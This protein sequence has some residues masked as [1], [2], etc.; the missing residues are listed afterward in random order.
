MTLTQTDTANKRHVPLDK[1]RNIGII[2][3]IDAG[4]TT[5]TERILFYT[6]RTYKLG[7]IDEGTT[8]MDWM[9]QERER[10][11]TIV[12][13]A[14]TAFWTPIL[15]GAIPQEEYR[16]NIIDTPGHV[17]F[18]A[19]VERSLRVLDGGITVLDAEEGVQSQS[20]TVWHQADKYKVPRLCFVNKMDK[21]GAD[22]QATVQDIRDRLGANPVIMA[23][24]IG[25]EN[26]F[27]GICLLLDQKALI[28]KGDETGAKYDIVD[29]PADMKT[30]VKKYRTKLIE[31]ISEHDDKLLEKFLNAEEPTMVELKAALRKAVIAYKL[32]PV[33]CGSSLRN[34]GVQ[35]LLDAVVE[36]LPSPVDLRQV[37][38][39]NPKT[40]V[41]EIR[42]CNSEAPFCGLAF[43]I[44]SDPHVGRL[45]YVRIYSGTLKSGSYVYNSTKDKK[46]RIGRLLLMHA[47]DREEI[48]EAFS[49]EIVA[50]VGLKDTTT[51][52]TLTDDAHP[53]VLE[54]ITFTDPVISLAIEPKTKADQEKMGFALNRLG[55]ED[56][57]FTIKS[58]PETGQTIISGMGELHLDILVDRMKREFHVEANTGQPQVA[59]K[60]TIKKAA[61][62]E[63]KYIK[64]TG[65]HGQY[66]HCLLRVEPKA[67]GE[68]FE[69]VSEITGGSIPREFIPPIGK[70]A[71]EA[72]ENGV[73]AGF[74]LVDVKVAV[75]DGSYHDVDSSEIAFKIAGSMA[76]QSAVK[77]ADPVLL[78]PIMKLEVSSPEEFMG[79]V[80][81]DLSKKRARILGTA[82]RGRVLIINA[83]VPLAEMPQYATILRSM[84]QGRASFYMEPSHYEEVPNNIAQKIIAKAKPGSAETGDEKSSKR[85]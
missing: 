50:L 16:I 45:T 4:K 81:G 23:L 5:T 38:G 67:R 7:D 41:E 46:E 19:E 9:A 48:P 57:T 85:R 75:Y 76:F 36:Y 73:I 80:I 65:G 13:A 31:Q 12:S 51:G 8:Q 22:F 70:G 35:S 40:K 42:A 62:A 43:K 34:K 56:P 39:T 18:T 58:D 3:H 55:E 49:G 84:T 27:K 25:A 60:E 53:I 79:E 74:P 63:G 30:E 24:P 69:F 29:I 71:K 77:Q 14:T 1:I 66:G 32:V 21:L 6:G 2:A 68:G 17:D 54:G 78:E 59:Y 72:A 33:F 83:E 37:K 15:P 26:T 28:W 61:Q 44:Q 52:N 64:Q 11:I 20:E 10:G 82:K 47:N